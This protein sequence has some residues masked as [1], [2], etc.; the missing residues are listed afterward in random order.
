MKSFLT[1]LREVMLEA[2]WPTD[3]FDN[4]VCPPSG[5]KPVKSE[6]QPPIGYDWHSTYPLPYPKKRGPKQ[7][8]PWFSPLRKQ[9]KGY[10]ITCYHN[11]KKFTSFWLSKEQTKTIDTKGDLLRYADSIGLLR[12]GTIQAVRVV[13]HKAIFITAK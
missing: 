3:A 13:L 9:Y 4:G 5:G 6:P 7:G 2:N 12:R 8:F 1:E 10:C 11:G